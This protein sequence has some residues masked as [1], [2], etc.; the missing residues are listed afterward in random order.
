MISK[1]DR[2]KI[3]EMIEEYGNIREHYWRNSVNMLDFERSNENK[4][5]GRL[6]GKIESFLICCK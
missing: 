6:F 2:I 5:I 3:L 4:K 1:A